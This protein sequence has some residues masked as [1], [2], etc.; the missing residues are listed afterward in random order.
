MRPRHGW[1]SVFANL[2]AGIGFFVGIAYLPAFF[3]SVSGLSAT[4]SGLLL[5]PF[6]VS[7]AAG[8]VFVG[9]AVERTG[10][11]TKG[12]PVAGMVAM[13]VGFALLGAVEVGT[14]VGL[15]AAVSVIAGL[16]V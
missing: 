1:A 13:A 10:V 16:G 2:V 14:P 15:V 12:F 5:V 3:E 8:T 4:E 6:A 7:V 11:G 9:Q